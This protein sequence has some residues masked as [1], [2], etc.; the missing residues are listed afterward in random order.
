MQIVHEPTAPETAPHTTE[1][2]ATTSSEDAEPRLLIPAH[3]YTDTPLARLWRRT[4]RLR[5]QVGAYHDA[6]REAVDPLHLEVVL[7]REHVA[8][9]KTERHR[10]ADLGTVIDEL[11][12][13]TARLAVAEDEDEAW[14]ALSDCLM[15]R[16]SLAQVSV[17]VET[18]ISAARRRLSG[19]GLVAGLG[20]DVDAAGVAQRPSG[21]PWS[22]GA[23]E[24][25]GDQSAAV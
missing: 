13:V 11:R 5:G 12:H 15:I 2:R 10:P 7:L 25:S 14:G 23:V 24:V 16:E 18:A 17:E 19:P 6:G 9:L 3:G 8:R 21:L 1:P 22:P 4:A 20:L